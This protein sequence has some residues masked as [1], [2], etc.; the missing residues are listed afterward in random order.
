ME[1]TQSNVTVGFKCPYCEKTY[2]REDNCKT[3][4]R[5]IHEG[6]KPQCPLCGIFLRSG[7][8]KRHQNTNKCKVR[9]LN[10]QTF[11]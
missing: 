1:G 2:S 7:S 9:C 3:H 4:I 6:K 11:D 10:T 8:M 5:E